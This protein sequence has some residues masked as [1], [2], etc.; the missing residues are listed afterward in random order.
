MKKVTVYEAYDGVRF[1]TEKQCREHDV[2]CNKVK[3]IECK[4]RSNAKVQA[5]YSYA[6]QQDAD[7]VKK[8]FAELMELCTDLFGYD[9]FERVASGECDISHAQYILSDYS[10]DYPLLW[11]FFHRFLHIDMKTS[12]EYQQQFYATHP[13]AFKGVIE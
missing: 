7:T 6:V 3:E 2:I 13:E 12:I 9:K 4:L 11:M 10:D 5:N 8:C 1:D